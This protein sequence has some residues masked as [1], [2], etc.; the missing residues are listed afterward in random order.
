MGVIYNNYEKDSRYVIKRNGSKVPFQTDKIERAILKAMN[1]INES[2]TE[3]AEKIARLSTKALFRN[4]KDRVPHVDDVHD[5]VENKLM[6]NGLNEI[7]K[8]YI[9]YGLKEEGIFFL[10]EQTLNPM[11][12]QI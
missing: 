6:D 1:G 9:L 7:A 10:K 5:M 12:I 11:S 8:E 2:D 3:M 4:N